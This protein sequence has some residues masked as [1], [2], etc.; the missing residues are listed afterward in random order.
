MIYNNIQSNRYYLLDKFSNNTIKFSNIVDSNNIIIEELKD[1]LMLTITYLDNNRIIPPIIDN[2]M[3]VISRAISTKMLTSGL[4]R[5]AVSY[6]TAT[7]ESE[8]SNI[9][10]ITVGEN[11]IV[12]IKYMKT[13]NDNVLGIKIY[14][15]RVINNTFDL[16]D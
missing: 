4:Y 2:S 10:D 3:I 15:T 9:F 13:D 1:S 16:V 6:Y 12:A 14:R 7:A 11:Q 5:Y 8:M